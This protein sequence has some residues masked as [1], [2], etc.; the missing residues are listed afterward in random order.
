MYQLGIVS[1]QTLAQSN[2]MDYDYEN[3]TRTAENLA[4]A[5]ANAKA[6]AEAAGEIQALQSLLMN[7][8]PPQTSLAQPTI[9]QGQMDQLFTLFQQM[10]PPQAKKTMDEIGAQNPELARALQIRLRTD[11]SVIANQTKELM[12]MP[13]DQ[14]DTALQEITQ[15]NPLMGAMVE[16]MMAQFGAANLQTAGTSTPAKPGAGKTDKNM[17][18]QKA[19]IRKGGSPM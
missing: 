14:R 18:A 5:I 17:P 15:S 7:A 10:K 1:G 4:N 9:P 2:D 19:P 8:M 11:P 16:N 13:T 3:T 6:Q 12:V